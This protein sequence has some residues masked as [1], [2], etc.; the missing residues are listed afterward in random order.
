MNR[1]KGFA[2]LAGSYALAAT[3]LA[4]QDAAPPKPEMT[5]AEQAGVQ[6]AV[7]LGWRVYSYDQAAWH[8]TDAMLEDLPDASERGIAGWIVNDIADG[9]ET[10]FFRP[11]DAGFEAAWAGVYNGRKVIRRT[12]YAPGERAL[13]PDEVALVEANLLLRRQRPERCS[14]SPFNSVIFPTGKPDGGL[15]AYLLTPQEKVGEIPFGGHHRFEIVDGKITDSRQFT[16][17]RITL[18]AST[19]KKGERP[20]GLTVSHILDATPTE[21][22]V[23]SAY[24]A[25]MSVY[26]ITPDND[27]VW[28]VEVSGGRPRIRIVR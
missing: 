17:S 18:P 7:D 4:A 14:A 13:V 21:L 2:I 24:A 5:E 22:H 15:Y 16:K 10:V 8:G 26:V 27:R 23:F 6:Q 1:F 28:A 12:T 3:P 19:G 25:N 20:V 11:T 9:W